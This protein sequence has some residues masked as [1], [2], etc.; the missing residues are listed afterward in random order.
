MIDWKIRD[1][2]ETAKFKELQRF[3]NKCREVWPGSKI[4]IRAS[5]SACVDLTPEMPTTG[6]EIKESAKM[7]KQFDDT[8]RGVLFKND[9]KVKPDD[10]DFS[11]QVNVGGTEYWVSA[12][13]KISKKGTKFLSFSIKPKDEAR[14]RPEFDDAIDF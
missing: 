13:S 3:T 6:G 5:D 2:E 7:N 1:A 14:A 10:R 12:W 4:I 11:G 9:K 8:N